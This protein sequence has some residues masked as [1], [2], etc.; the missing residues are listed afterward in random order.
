[1]HIGL[2]VNQSHEKRDKRKHNLAKQALNTI[3]RQLI[4]RTNENRDK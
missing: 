3:K 1:M 4:Q 2:I